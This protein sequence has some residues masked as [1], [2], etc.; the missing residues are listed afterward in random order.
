MPELHD[1][2]QIPE[3]PKLFR[4]F[5]SD[6]EEFENL[7]QIWEFASNCLQ[8]PKPFK[9]EELYAGLK[10]TEDTEEVTLVSDIVCEILEMAIKEIPD[11]QKEDDDSLLWMIKQVSEDKVKFIWPCLI[12]IFINSGLF[13]YTASSEVNEIGEILQSAT[14]KT[15]NS[16]LT[17]DQKIKILLFLCNSCHDFVAFREYLSERLKEKHKYS[18]EK[19]DTYT[20]IRK[21]EQEKRKLMEEHATSD[22]VHNDK[23]N[24]K[25]VV[26]EEE[27]KNASR[28]QGKAIRDQ[29]STLTKEKEEFR[30]SLQEL[31]DKIEALNN[32]IS[33]LNDSL[34][35]VSVK[36]SVIGRDMESE[37][38]FF[39]D[40]N[41]KLYVKNL[42]TG[43]WGY[44]N[45]EESIQD[46]ENSLLT[47]GIKERKLYE[48][49]RRLKGKMKIKKSKDLKMDETH[50]NK[51]NEDVEMKDNEV[52]NK[53]PNEAQTTEPQTSEEKQ[54]DM[55]VDKQSDI[56]PLKE[57]ELDP[58]YEDAE[59]EIDWDKCLERA[60]G[61]SIKRTEINTRRSNRG[62]SKR[63][64]M[65]T[66]ESIKEKLIEL[67]EDY[68][69]A[70]KEL[71]KA[72]APFSTMEKVKDLLVKAEDEET[73]WEILINLET[74]FSLPMNMKRTEELPASVKIEVD[75][76]SASNISGKEMQ[77]SKKIIEEGFVFYHNNR[78]VKKFWSS[79]TLRDSWK[80]YLES[81]Q[82]GSISALFL[83]V[84]IFIDQTEEYI[85][86]M[87]SRVENKKKSE[88]KLEKQ[89]MN[90]NPS[91]STDRNDRKRTKGFYKESSEEE[92]EGEESQPKRRSK[93]QKTNQES[94]FE[95]EMSVDEESE[96]FE[97]EEEE[98]DAQ[99]DDLCYVCKKKGD[100]ICCEKCSHV[101]HIKCLGLRQVPENDWYCTACLQKM[102]NTRQTRSSRRKR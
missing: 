84:C 22:F 85:E 25:I 30:D 72:W 17:Y 2:D 44:Y 70:A 92:S 35:K 79:D 63:L 41:T 83:S 76:E 36:V 75:G 8:M 89:K 64:D 101:A 29:L 43:Q 53:N 61:F 65:L 15:F 46:L 38:W 39:K 3:R 62:N 1:I 34:F 27:L 60:L 98:S 37:Y 54:K 95:D 19:Q 32:K 13:E 77:S 33:R 66:L 81:I 52:Q 42:K 99:W 40:D 21:V 49:L 97:E 14:P 78:K 4:V 94:E 88:E 100:V 93:R 69:E 16:L 86:K 26:L 23:I 5:L 20:D 73:I 48:G 6:S 67:E 31:D 55:E 56:K 90:K 12:G 68:T 59:E 82:N 24:D 58:K 71:G 9:V 50:E 11:E 47:K 45:D 74:G 80:D 28:T 18:K 7:L 91:R 87:N 102:Q 96:D 57:A 51:E 10:F